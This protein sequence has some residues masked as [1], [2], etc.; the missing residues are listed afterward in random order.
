M[1]KFAVCIL[2]LAVVCTSAF[3]SVL[4]VGATGRFGGDFLNIEDYKK[5][6][7]YDFGADVRLNV[8]L[9]NLSANV[10]F[11]K[12]DAG[13]FLLNSIITANLRFDLKV[14]DIALGVGYQ[15]P[16]EFAKDQV[17]INGNPVSDIGLLFKDMSALLARAAVGVNLGPLG[18]SVDYKI[19]FTTVIGYFKSEDKSN[20]ESF[21]AGK[22]AFSVLVN[23]I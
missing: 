4:Q 12:S 19:P 20:F 16:V 22:V 9:F 11:G 7:K 17:L 1:K 21:K 23:L 5:V 6:S 13:N 14:V 2:I 18:V 3:A 10:L 15:V 8:S